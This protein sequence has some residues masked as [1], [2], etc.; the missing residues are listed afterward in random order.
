M[1]CYTVTTLTYEKFHIQLAA[2]GYVRSGLG[3]CPSSVAN[4]LCDFG[5]GFNTLKLFS[6]TSV[7]FSRS[8]VS[9]SLQPH[10]SQPARP[11]CRSPTP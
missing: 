5:I 3:F 8:V 9:D 7:Q 11:P 6:F 2:E 1:Y 10:K 4:K